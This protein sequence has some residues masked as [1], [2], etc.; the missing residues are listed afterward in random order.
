MARD[1]SRSRSASPPRSALG[2]I[3]GLERERTKA[4][5]GGFAGVRTF[6]LIAL[7]G[8][9][10]RT[11]ATR[12]ARRR[13]RSCCSSASPGLLV[14]SYSLRSR[15]AERASPR[16]SRR[17]SRSL[18]GF[19]CV[20][21]H[22]S[23]S[24]RGSRW[25]AAACSRCATGCTA[26]PSGSRPPTS[27]PRSS[28]RWSRSSSCR[29]FPTSRSV[30][31]PFDMLT[32]YKVWLMVVLI[33]GL[34]FASYLLVKF[35]GPE[36]GIGLTGL[37]GGL[38]SSTAVTLG[39]AQRS[40]EPG[41]EPNAL[42]LGTLI[43]WTIMFARIVVIVAVLVPALARR[44]AG[45]D[46]RARARVARH[47]LLPV[48]ARAARRTN[49]RSPRARTRSSSARR[50]ASASRSARSRSAPTR[51]S[52]TSGRRASTWRARSRE[53]RTWTRSRCPWPSSCAAAPRSSPPRRARS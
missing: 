27:R 23:R 52:S 53:S 16:S 13:W 37:L 31:P 28:S 40:R 50:S 30:P 4:D 44:A 15:R 1:R 47:R 12:S 43:A 45:L 32:P 2:V 33:S 48:A 20:R 9:S 34:N 46:G 35:L 7:A 11:W 42:A 19:L 39:F 29:W 36:H 10:R 51:R 5:E 24:R 18:L 3:L 17:C 14:A 25:R 49:T 41:A 8:G 21:E 26:S 6:G 22:R 38:V